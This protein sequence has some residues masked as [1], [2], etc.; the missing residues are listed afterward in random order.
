MIH[1]MAHCE[2]LGHHERHKS[3]LAKTVLL[4]IM[5]DTLYHF[6]SNLQRGEKDLAR[7]SSEFGTPTSLR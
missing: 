7:E 6:A 4:F 2:R 3:Q 1:A 5:E